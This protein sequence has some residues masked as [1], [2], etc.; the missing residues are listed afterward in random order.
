[1]IQPLEDSLV[2]Y[3]KTKCTLIKQ[4]YFLIFTHVVENLSPHKKLYTDYYISFIHN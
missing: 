3:Y 4:S 1:M 2:V